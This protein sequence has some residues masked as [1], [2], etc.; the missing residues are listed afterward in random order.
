MNQHLIELQNLTKTYN[1]EV[2]AVTA[3]DSVNLSI[4]AGEFVAIMGPSGS[5]KSTLMNLLGC[6]D[7]PTTG[8]YWLGGEDVSEFTKA[9]RADVRNHRIGF[10]FQSYNLLSRTS[11]LKN[12]MLPLIYGGRERQSSAE[13]QALAQEALEAVGLGD[14]IRH[15]PNQLSGGQQQRVAI[16]RALVNEPLIILADEPTGN[17]DLRSSQEILDILHNLHQQ[18]RTIM[19]ITHE[20]DLAAQAQRTVLLRD[21]QIVNGGGGTE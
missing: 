2:I 5:G 15:R 19:M 12:V 14:R 17:L 6:L 8:R 9:Q 1:S 11:A 16:A 20:P 10:I 13:R 3:L 21:G 18:G 7:R 4:A